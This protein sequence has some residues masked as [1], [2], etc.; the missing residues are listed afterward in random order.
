MNPEEKAEIIIW[1]WLKTKSKFVL[2]VYF[3]RKNLINAPVFTTQGINKKPDFIIE[4]DRGYG[5]EYIIVEI[6]SSNESKNVHDAR[7][8]MDY[9]E[10]YVKGK[11]KYFINEKEIKINHFLVATE[12]SVKGYL[13][14][15][16]I[17][18]I[19]NS[20]SDDNW[21]ATNSKYKLEPK[22]EY[23]LTSMWVRRLWADFRYFRLTNDYPEKPSLGILMCEFSEEKFNPSMMIMNYNNHIR[24]MKW[25][26]RWWEI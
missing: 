22:K 9:Y 16:E 15:N 19:E 8:I 25:G 1:D 10:R 23:L 26:A 17:E 13:F 20:K 7:K 2:E 14:M 18:I 21:R 6:K 3:N 12:N 11:T 4:I 5:I 24:N